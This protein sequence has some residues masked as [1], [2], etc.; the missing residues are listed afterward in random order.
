MSHREYARLR[1][2][3]YGGDTV[4]KDVVEDGEARRD[5]WVEAEEGSG[6]DARFSFLEA[7]RPV[8]EPRTLKHAPVSLVAGGRAVPAVRVPEAGKS[9][10]PVFEDWDAVVQREGQREVEAERKRLQAA[11]EEQ[12]RLERVMK[13]AEEPERGSG[14]ES[15]WESEWEGIQSEPEAEWLTQ[16]RPGRKTQTERNKIR[17]RKEAERLATRERKIREKEQQVN[18]VKAFARMVEAEQRAKAQA[19]AAAGNDTS[20]EDGE[21]VLRR[22]KFGKIP[23]VLAVSAFKFDSR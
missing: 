20:S 5:L 11:L 9:Y 14:D 19:V 15:A 21:E 6:R 12:E 17:R 4:R 8:R 2:I 3:A 18:Q 16:K 10:N 1:G 23:Y 22:R 13:V 7:Q